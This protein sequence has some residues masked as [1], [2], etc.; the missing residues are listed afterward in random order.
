M[1][2]LI[3]DICIKQGATYKLS[4]EYKD[5]YGQPINLTGCTYAM[6]VRD[7]YGGKLLADFTPYISSPDP[8]NGLIN[9]EVPAEITDTYS[10]D[11]ARHDLV[12]IYSDGTVER[13]IEG[14]AFLNQAVT[15]IDY[16]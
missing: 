13:I 5:K 14:R 10:F 11:K 12:V 8:V 1:N 2:K 4:L 6:E 9:V 3:F 15:E 7:T 16:V